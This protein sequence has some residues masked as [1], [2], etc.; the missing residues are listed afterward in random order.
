MAG[1]P[2]DPAA[3]LAAVLDGM[4]EV[5][6]SRVDPDTGEALEEV[7][8]VPAD[9]SAVRDADGPV[10]SGEVGADECDWEVCVLGGLNFT[11]KARDTITEPDGT[12]W[13]V[14]E[15]TSDGH[16]HWCPGCVK[17]R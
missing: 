16:L 5:T 11:P 6:L 10:G 17:Q 8:G 15:V 14:G 9:R 7:S 3:D 12:V 1:I 13:V 2:V 4:D